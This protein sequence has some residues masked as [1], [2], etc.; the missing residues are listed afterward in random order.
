MDDKAEDTIVYLWPCN[1]ETWA[2][3]CAIQSQW[4]YSGMG[5]A[6]GLDYGGVLA[7]LKVQG[8]R[9]KAQREIFTGIQ[10]AERGT[11][12]G[13]AEKAKNK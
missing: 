6:T 13:M 12:R 9:G 3:W 4:R 8:M 5:G 7:Y 2:H 1:S 11:L 10:A